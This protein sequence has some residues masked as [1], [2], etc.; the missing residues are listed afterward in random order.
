MAP[1]N[2]NGRADGRTLRWF[3]NLSNAM[4]CI[5]QTIIARFAAWCEMLFCY[6]I[7]LCSLWRPNWQN[8]VIWR[9]GGIMRRICVTK[10]FSGPSYKRVASW[11]VYELCIRFITVRSV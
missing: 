10:R 3:Y 2:W 7:L 1:Q 5:G 8:L 11:H 6:Y 9:F 4:H